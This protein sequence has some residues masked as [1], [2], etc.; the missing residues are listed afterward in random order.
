M[1]KKT[2]I[3]R[4]P[5]RGKDFLIEGYVVENKESRNVMCSKLES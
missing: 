5:I 1:V 2:V 4:M 3:V